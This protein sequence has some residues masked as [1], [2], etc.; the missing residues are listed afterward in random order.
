MDDRELAKIRYKPGARSGSECGFRAA[1]A[2]MVDRERRCAGGASKTA[3]SRAD[4]RIEAVF[5]A[6]RSG[7]HCA[8][9]HV[10]FLPAL[11]CYFRQRSGG[12]LQHSRGENA[13]ELLCSSRAFDESGGFFAF[14]PGL[15]D[16]GL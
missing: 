16:A 3:A 2:N 14:E 15:K 10:S 5:L 4:Y 1:S 11:R 9:A 6:N 8:F 13:L 7:A 12:S